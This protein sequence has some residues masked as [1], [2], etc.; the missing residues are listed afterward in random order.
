MRDKT[1][2]ETLKVGDPVYVE[3]TGMISGLERTTVAKLTKATITVALY[4]QKFQRSN[5]YTLIKWGHS[6]IIQDTP[7]M[8]EKAAVIGLYKAA[9]RMVQAIHIPHNR[10]DLESLIEAIRP[11]TPESP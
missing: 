11:F 9:Y 8:N 4:D 10:K 3:A 7:E 6:R 5:G 2:L 1:W